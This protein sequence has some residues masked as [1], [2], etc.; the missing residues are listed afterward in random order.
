MLSIPRNEKASVMFHAAMLAI[1]MSAAAAIVADIRHAHAA[2]LATPWTELHASRV[3][4]IAGRAGADQA[5]Y[6]AG[7]EIVLADGWKTY[8]RMPGDSGVPPSFDW[9][10]SGNLAK[11]TTLFP[12]PVRM[13]EAGGMAIGYKGSVLLPIRIVP[14]DPTRPVS[15]K[16]A[17]E[18]GVCREICIPATANF[19]L[20]IPAASTAPLPPEIVSALDRV[21]RSQEAR[22]KSDPKLES[23]SIDRSGPSPKLMIEAF[24]A[25]GAKNADIFIEAPEGLYVP[26]PRQVTTSA[27]GRVRFETAVGTELAQDLKGK[28]LTFTMVSDAGA[29][30]AMWVVP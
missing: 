13:P 3:R 21:P 30:E 20:S 6:V 19:E 12:A 27:N 9:T 26:M 11:A 24:F 8:W 25:D 28:T 5:H 14:Q 18:L 23:A 10:G 4:L 17:L 16:L 7:L 1:F 15:L 29:A 2:S 22:R